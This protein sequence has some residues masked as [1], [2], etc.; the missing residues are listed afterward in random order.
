MEERYD[1]TTS[2]AHAH[3]ADHTRSAQYPARNP[4]YTSRTDPPAPA[5]ASTNTNSQTAGS[6][7]RWLAVVRERTFRRG[8]GRA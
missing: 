6:N 2:R 8:A 4:E 7:S 1:T 5:P 3:K